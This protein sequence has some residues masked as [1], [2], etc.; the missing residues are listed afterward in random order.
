MANSRK[1]AYGAMAYYTIGELI[2]DARER[3]NYSQEELSYGICAASTL[4]RIENGLQAPG[5]KILDGLMQRLGVTD[6]VCNI[7]LSQEEWERYELEQQLAHSLGNRDFEQAEFF[8]SNIERNIKKNPKKAQRLKM[9]E[10]Y[11]AFARALIQEQKGKSMQWVLQELLGAI[12]MTMPDFDGVHIKARLLT[13]H[14]IAILN[15]IG[16]AYHSLGRAL[17]GIQLLSELKGYMETH[18]L[19]DNEMSVTYPMVLQT[20]SSCLGKTGMCK[21]ALALCQA[22]I[23]YCIKYGKLHTF[24][25][26]LCNKACA[27]AELGQH[28]MS[29]EFFLQS[30][31]VF[32]AVNQQEHAEQ[33]KRYARTHYGIRI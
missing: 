3:Q 2:R 18:I 12:H 17:D 10:Q 32:Q 27:L 9:E 19:Q 1:G 31:A 29:K 7:Y 22:G 33:V 26:L 24:P 11:L 25:M 16:C 23:D 30:S 6:R 4:S 28:D 14:E 5:K 13:Y 20:L 21:D 15:S 8:A